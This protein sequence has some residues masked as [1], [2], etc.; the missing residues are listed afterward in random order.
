[1]FPTGNTDECSEFTTLGD[2]F[3]PV[4]NRRV[5]YLWHFPRQHLRFGAEFESAVTASRSH[6]HT[7]DNLKLPAFHEPIGHVLLL[8][9]RRAHPQWLASPRAVLGVT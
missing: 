6:S 2:D 5:T 4:P 3:A 1:M 7:L 8:V 9:G